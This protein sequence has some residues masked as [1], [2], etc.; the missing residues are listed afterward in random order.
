MLIRTRMD[1]QVGVSSYHAVWKSN[2][3]ELMTIWMILSYRMQS[4]RY[5]TQVGKTKSTRWAAV[6]LWGA[7]TGGRVWEGLWMDP[8]HPT[9]RVFGAP[10]RPQLVKPWPRKRQQTFQ[11]RLAWLLWPQW[12][13]H[14]QYH[15]GQRWAI[16]DGPHPNSWPMQ[17]MVSN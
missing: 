16:P 2:K 11:E 3:N 7:L 9:R 15:V 14:S 6:T 1:T 4:A 10:S 13:H 17:R 8:A 5:H 12:S